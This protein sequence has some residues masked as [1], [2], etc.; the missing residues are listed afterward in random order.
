MDRR[1]ALPLA[2]AGSCAL[3]AAVSRLEASSSSPEA[4]NS[5]A[6][7]STS[8]SETSSNVEHSTT[9]KFVGVYLAKDSAS[10]LRQAA[11]VQG[12]APLFVVL[13][14]NPSEAEREA[15]A[16]LLGSPAKLEVRGIAADDRAQAALVRVT[17]TRG[18]PIEPLVDAQTAH[19]ALWSADNSGADAA[20]L[21]ERLGAADK[22]KLLDD[23]KAED[24]DSK[25][26]K[27]EGELPA[28]DSKLLPLFNPFP[29]GIASVKKL[30]QPLELDGT[31]CASDSFDTETMTCSTPKAECGFCK[32][33][34]A[35]PCGAEFSAWEACLDNCKAKNLDFI[36]HCGKETIVLRDCVDANPEYYHVLQDGPDDAPE[37]QEQETKEQ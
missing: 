35:G 31:V 4:S 34:K 6:Q 14:F 26:D 15:F 21:L 37:E 30:E 2:A 1:S 33:M 9:P 13:K 10:A 8:G 28:F 11:S 16:P 32:F 7:A 25:D 29:A 5:D 18:E 19:V 20:V 24:E 17:T 3:S 12:D 23:K 27:W 36:D 22:L